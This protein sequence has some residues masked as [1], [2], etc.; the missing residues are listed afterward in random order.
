MELCW[1]NVCRWSDNHSYVDFEVPV[2]GLLA[3][4]DALPE[5]GHPKRL[6][7]HEAQALALSSP[8]CMGFTFKPA[9]MDTASGTFDIF[10]KRSFKFSPPEDASGNEWVCYGRQIGNVSLKEAASPCAQSTQGL[11]LHL[12]GILFICPLVGIFMIYPLVDFFGGGRSDALIVILLL[13]AGLLGSVGWHMCTSGRR[14]CCSFDPNSW[15]ACRNPARADLLELIENTR[16]QSLVPLAAIRDPSHPL[17]PQ[18]QPVQTDDVPD[19]G[20]QGGA[21]TGRAETWLGEEEHPSKSTAV[22]C[23]ICLEPLWRGRAGVLMEKGARVCRHILHYRCMAAALED[24]EMKLCPLCRA[25]GTEIIKVPRPHEDPLRWF[26]LMDVDGRFALTKVEVTDALGAQMD[27]EEDALSD[28]VN[29]AWGHWDASGTG[30]INVSDLPGLLDFVRDAHLPPTVHTHRPFESGLSFGTSPATPD[31]PQDPAVSAVP[32]KPVGGRPRQLTIGAQWKR[33]KA[34]NGRPYWYNIHTHESRWRPPGQRQ[35]SDCPICGVRLCTES[36]GVL[37]G[38]TS[39]RRACRHVFHVN[40]IEPTFRVNGG[41]CPECKITN[42]EVRHVPQPEVSPWQWFL[43][44]DVDGTERL[45]RSEVISALSIH[46]NLPEQFIHDTVREKWQHWDK[47]GTGTIE[48]DEL[49]HLIRDIRGYQ[50]Q[51]TPPSLRRHNTP[52]QRP[53]GAPTW[54]RPAYRTQSAQD[55]S[56]PHPAASGRP[57][58]ARNSGVRI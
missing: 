42:V 41:K 33:T 22:D 55:A 23:V 4:G 14:R 20:S 21:P 17:L 15:L 29:R 6:P 36:V 52:P 24:A 2:D 5:L 56:A 58:V 7:V 54:T 57:P 10:F 3:V 50:R 53:Q 40:C 38:T 13:Y 47:A 34:P 9:S 25:K 31:T 16:A 18:L 1:R 45:T 27:V 43:L 39:R 51:N 37:V 12:F 28:V 8:E 26:T 48:L 30:V 44:M 32:G 49:P 19:W 46:V 11:W 35:S